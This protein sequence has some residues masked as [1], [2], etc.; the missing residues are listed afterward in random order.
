[1]MI[2]PEFTKQQKLAL[3]AQ[4]AFAHRW[5]TKFRNDLIRAIETDQLFA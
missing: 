4:S 3:V 2:H 1:M 5:A